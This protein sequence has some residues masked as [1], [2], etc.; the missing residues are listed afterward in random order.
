MCEKLLGD[1]PYVEPSVKRRATVSRGQNERKIRAELRTAGGEISLKTLGCSAGCHVR[2]NEE[3]VANAC[4]R[5][6]SLHNG[7]DFAD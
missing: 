2:A 1:V 6:K 7:A 5:Q 3:M 4:F